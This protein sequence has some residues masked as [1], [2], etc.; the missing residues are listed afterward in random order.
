VAL[1]AVVIALSAGC[2][3]GGDG[4]GDTP[5]GTD[6]SDG[7]NAV[8][9]PNATVE[10]YWKSV[11]SGEYGEA[12][13]LVLGETL[14]DDA[15]YG[16]GGVDTSSFEAF[17]DSGENLT[18]ERVHFSRAVRAAPGNQYVEEYGA[19][20]GYLVSYSLEGTL[21]KGGA[22]GPYERDISEASM[23]SLVLKVDG[24][25]RIVPDF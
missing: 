5:T 18:V 6:L 4:S 22:R 8:P 9:Q 21:E 3:G 13:E 16:S 1:L 24:E 19:D 14:Y 7:S 10:N 12:E 2:V 25:W 23:A 15:L 20:E 11:A 17:G